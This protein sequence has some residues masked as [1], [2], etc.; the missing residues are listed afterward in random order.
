[1]TQR[2]EST[3][4]VDQAQGASPSGCH[5]AVGPEMP[6]A[7]S[8]SRRAFLGQMSGVTVA[9]LATG[10]VGVAMVSGT[11]SPMA[12]AA[13]MAPGDLQNRRWQ[14][15][16]L[17]RDA[18]IAHSN[19]PL[20]SYPTNGD[21]AVYPSKI[22]SFTKGLPHNDLG[23]GEPTAYAALLNALTTGQ[24]AAFEAIPLGGR[25]KLANPQAA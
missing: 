12:H 18:A 21:E 5:D 24:P 17:R 16:R 1:M 11:N 15:Y 25:M 8:L 4:P 2:P 7:P 6:S 9:T 19:L 23:E 22:A 13:E 14:A 20:P 3:T 10:G